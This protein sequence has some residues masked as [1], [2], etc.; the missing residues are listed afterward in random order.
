MFTQT[1]LHSVLLTALTEP[2]TTINN[3]KSI[4]IEPASIGRRICLN[5]IGIDPTVN[6]QWT[7]TTNGTATV[8]P[9]ISNIND[10]NPFINISFTNPISFNSLSFSANA[11]D[12]DAVGM[13]VLLFDSTGTLIS[14]RVTTADILTTNACRIY[15]DTVTVSKS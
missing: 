4:R 2:S 8:L 13:K 1:G 7:I 11:T 14:N 3:I 9:Y 5:A 12:L 10:I 6:S 15:Y